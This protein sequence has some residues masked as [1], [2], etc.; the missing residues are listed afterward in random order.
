MVILNIS[1][2]LHTGLNSKVQANQSQFVPTED[3]PLSTSQSADL[4]DGMRLPPTDH[5]YSPPSLGGNLQSDVTE[6]SRDHRGRCGMHLEESGDLTADHMT[7]DRHEDDAGEVRGQPEGDVQNADFANSASL[8]DHAL[9]PLPPPLEADGHGKSTQVDP[10]SHATTPTNQIGEE[11]IATTTVTKSHIAAPTNQMRVEPVGKAPT[12]ALSSFKRHMCETYSSD[13]DDVFLPNPPSKSQ[14][15][16]CLVST[17]TSE[18]GGGTAAAT[19]GHTLKVVVT[20]ASGDEGRE[21]QGVESVPLQ[22]E[23]TTE[24]MYVCM[25]VCMCICMYVYVCM[26]V[27]VSMY[28]CMYVRMKVLRRKPVGEGEGLGGTLRSQYFIQLYVQPWP[29]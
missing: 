14:A 10:E 7:N 25:Y 2:F 5:T 8:S 12:T 26:C 13:D 24:G 15:D 22:H 20:S 1:F 4:A 19:A 21:G 28:V 23:S 18:D 6:E 9:T 3:A 27:Y 11:P 16:R 29:T 17:E